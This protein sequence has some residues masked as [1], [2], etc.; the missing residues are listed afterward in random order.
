M[1]CSEP[2]GKGSNHR[3]ELELCLCSHV[4]GRG[5]L[6]VR[7]AMQHQNGSSHILVQ[8][9]RP[10]RQRTLRHGKPQGIYQ[11]FALSLTRASAFTP[12]T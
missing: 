11:Q 1:R 8:L 9:S 12:L 3:L 10:T 2:G 7:M 4:G 5:L 6:R